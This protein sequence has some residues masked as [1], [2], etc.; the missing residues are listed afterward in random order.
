MKYFHAHARAQH[1]GITA[2]V[3]ARDSHTSAGYW[4]IVQD[5]LP[6]LVR[7]MLVRCYDQ[8]NQK[9][10]Y[11]HVRGLRGQVWL[12]AYPNLFLTIAPAEWTFYYPHFMQPYLQCVWAG[13]YLMA[14]HM[15]FLVRCMWR[16]LATRHGHKFFVV[17]EWVCKTEY[18]GRGIPHWHIAAWV[19]CHGILARLAGRTGTSVVSAFVKFLAAVFQCE[20]HV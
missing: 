8:Q 9:E 3:L 20:I 18:Q 4:V 11:D 13:A 5:S 6:D 1:M 2:D 7:I 10:L 17:F 19:A 15:Y 16:F 12:C 14:L